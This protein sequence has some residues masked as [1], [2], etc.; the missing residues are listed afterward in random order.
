MGQQSEPRGSRGLVLRFAAVSLAAFVPIGL[1]LS[2]LLSRQLVEQAE[3]ATTQQA[4]FVTTSILRPAI[5]DHDLS[6]LVPMTGQRFADFRSFVATR[7]IDHP[8]LLVRIWRSDGMVVFSSRPGQTGQ[9]YPALPVSVREAF[10]SYRTV[11]SVGS[12]GPE[13][14]QVGSLPARLLKTDVPIFFDPTARQ[15]IPVAVAEVYTDYSVVQSRVDKLVRI[16][17]GTLAIGLAILY[18][19]LL[20]IIRRISRRL[21]GQA[22]RLASLLR[23]EQSSQAERRR[24][25]ERT[26]RASEDERTRI[27]AEFH[28]GPVQRVAQLAYGLER[29]RIRLGRGD[30]EGAQDVLTRVQE[31][32]FEEVKELRTMMSQLRPPVLDQR[33]LEE[34]L[35]DRAAEVE[36]DSGVECVVRASLDGRLEPSLETVLY[37]VSQEALTNVS[38]HADARRVEISVARQNGSVRLEIS[39]DGKGFAPDEPRDDGMHFG[40]LAMRERVEMSGGSWQLDSRP[41]HG[42]TIKAVLP[43]EVIA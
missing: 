6:F 32:A 33:G 26:L 24:L 12:P 8:L 43:V 18:L 28:D 15:G 14:R 1:A 2:V 13:D 37:R 36:R 4:V 22:R 38:K 19:L 20:P 9:Q 5:T 30:I 3:E 42:T 41:G 7:I 39:D 16:L 35:R 23:T 27:A 10:R 25:L 11:T 17:V 34:A 21:Q 40:L 29:V 31:G